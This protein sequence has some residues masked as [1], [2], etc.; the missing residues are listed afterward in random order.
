MIWKPG[1]T[2]LVISLANWPTCNRRAFQMNKIAKWKINAPGKSENVGCLMQRGA[3]AVRGRSSKLVVAGNFVTEIFLASL[4]LRWFLILWYV[5]KQARRTQFK[6][7][8]SEYRVRI[9]IFLPSFYPWKLTVLTWINN[10][11]TR[12]FLLMKSGKL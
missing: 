10:M 6:L 1:T 3:E 4:Y 2:E 9:Y 5:F 8:G 11:K 7:Y 12:V